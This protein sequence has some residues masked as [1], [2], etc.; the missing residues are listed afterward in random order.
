MYAVQIRQAP[1]RAQTIRGDARKALPS[2]HPPL[3]D[4]SSDTERNRQ[5]ARFCPPALAAYRAT[6]G[7][8][9]PKSRAMPPQRFSRAVFL[10]VHRYRCKDAAQLCAPLECA[11]LEQPVNASPSRRWVR[12]RCRHTSMG[13]GWRQP[14][15]PPPSLYAFA[16][17]YFIASRPPPR[18]PLRRKSRFHTSRRTK[19][20]SSVSSRGAA[21]AQC[22]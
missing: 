13:R 21:R 12:V 16:A 14:A 5:V 18:P 19:A 1:S 3:G 2:M 20:F 10:P 22:R 8:S 15:R 4:P 6:F 7:T 17:K 9:Q 11:C